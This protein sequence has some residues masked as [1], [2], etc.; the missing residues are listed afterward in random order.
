MSGVAELIDAIEAGKSQDIERS[1]NAIMT[2]KLH[3]AIQAKREHISRNL[4]LPVH[5]SPVESAE[6][7][8]LE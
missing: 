7:E 6:I 8:E 1:F 4:M 3:D 5:E 2:D